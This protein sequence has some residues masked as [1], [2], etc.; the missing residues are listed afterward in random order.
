MEENTKALWQLQGV[1]CSGL[2]YKA[3]KGY[4]PR[5]TSGLTV[6]GRA[7]EIEGLTVSEIIP[8]LRPLDLIVW[9]GHVICMME[10]GK[11]IESVL[12]EG[13]VII[14]DAKMRLEHVVSELNRRPTN[15]LEKEGFMIRRWHPRMRVI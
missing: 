13:K 12:A 3:T 4:T 10:D 7:L 9:Q 8:L 5:N 15:T 11:T 14:R 6:F 2:L 1:D